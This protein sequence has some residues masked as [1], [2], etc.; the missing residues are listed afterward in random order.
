M[1]RKPKPELSIEDKRNRITAYDI[2]TIYEESTHG[3]Y[4]WLISLLTG[5]GTSPALRWSDAEVEAE[6]AEGDYANSR[7]K[8][9]TVKES[10]AYNLVK[11]LWP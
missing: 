7:G 11:E 8:E 2:V 5:E 6:W 9:A 10:A 4:A 1:K 3:Q